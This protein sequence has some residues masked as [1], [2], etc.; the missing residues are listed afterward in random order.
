MSIVEKGRDGTR[1]G[2]GRSGVS[3]EDEDYEQLNNAHCQETG[4]ENT[5]LLKTHGIETPYVL[6][7]RTI[8]EC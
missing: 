2:V 7:Q 4:V 5:V 1:E 3:K 6:A 8:Q